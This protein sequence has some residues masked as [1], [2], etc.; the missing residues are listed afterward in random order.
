MK[1]RHVW[2]QLKTSH[3]SSPATIL[4]EQITFNPKNP[5]SFFPQRWLTR[6]G[7]RNNSPNNFKVRNNENT[8]IC[9]E[10]E[11]KQQIL[12]L[13]HE[14]KTLQE[15]YNSRFS[16][17]ARRKKQPVKKP[18]YNNLAHRMYL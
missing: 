12:H 2:A 10:R 4:Q 6:K 11:P 14:G 16:R 9:S 5:S 15:I 17:V 8:F 18:Y 3:E 1:Y 13:C 7:S